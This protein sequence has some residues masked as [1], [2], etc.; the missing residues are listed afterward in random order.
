MLLDDNNS[1]K[2]LIICSDMRRIEKVHSKMNS[3]DKEKMIKILIYLLM[4]KYQR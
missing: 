2:D 1:D 3:K 4:M